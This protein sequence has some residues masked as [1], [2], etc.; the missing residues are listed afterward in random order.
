MLHVGLPK[1]GTTYLQELL[2]HHRD[3]LRGAGVLY[4]FVKPQAMFLGAVEV[5]GSRE[6]F[7]LTEADVAG[8]WA[9]LCERALAHDGVSVIS[10]EIL[11]GAEP[12]EIAVAL[13][14][15][16]GLRV[17]VVVTARDLGRQ[18]TAHWQ[19]EVKLGDVG[20]FADFEREQY[21]ADVPRGGPRPHFWHAQD[22]AAALAR[23]ATAVPADR[24][25][26]VTAPPPGAPAAT[27][28][29][30]F[31]DACGIPAGLVDPSSVPPANPSLNIEAIALL[32][33]VNQALAGLLT[34]REHAR[35]VKRDLAEGR[36]AGRPGTPARTPG[37][38]ADVLVPATRA[39]RAEVEAAAYSVH[40]DLDDLEPVLGGPDDPRPD[41]VPPGV[42]DPD[43]VDEAVRDVLSRVRSARVDSPHDSTGKA[44]NGRGGSRDTAGPAQRLRRRLGLDRDR[45]R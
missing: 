20:S 5:R 43:E 25:H 26:L 16:D 13:A 35:Y 30:R 36:L 14:P 45:P 2:A 42:P 23:W 17:D 31:A 40:G 15:L 37:D 9:A 44:G 41:D 12:D 32:R 8:T 21:R 1:T 18:A 38:L 27:L 24:V 29:E 10:H 33:A 19:E 39:W 34:P 7:G 3:E 28:W 4:P 11:G 6:K 22:H